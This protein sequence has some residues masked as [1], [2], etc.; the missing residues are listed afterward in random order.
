V[1]IAGITRI[2]FISLKEEKAGSAGSAMT[3]ENT[4]VLKLY[5]TDRIPTGS[6]AASH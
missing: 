5:L 2:P 1:V 6:I 3:A 4:S